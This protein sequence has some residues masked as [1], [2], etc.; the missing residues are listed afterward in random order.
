MWR[1]TRTPGAPRRRWW[2]SFRSEGRLFFLEVPGAPDKVMAVP[3]KVF[4]GSTRGEIS[5]QV[6]SGHLQTIGFNR[7]EHIPGDDHGGKANWRER[8]EG[9]A[10]DVLPL[11]G[12]LRQT[13]AS[14]STRHWDDYNDLDEDGR[15]KKK[16]RK[17]SFEGGTYKIDLPNPT[18]NG[19]EAGSS[20]AATPSGIVVEI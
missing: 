5:S 11:G 16:A 20:G 17:V 3:G 12:N 2:T 15:P 13:Q 1:S 14:E 4:R 9:E 19:A 8:V 10:L 18:T 6:L 7:H